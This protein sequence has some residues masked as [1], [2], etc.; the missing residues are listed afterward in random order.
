MAIEHLTML[1]SAAP[2]ATTV[3]ERGIEAF[4][5]RISGPLTPKR[6]AMDMPNL[7]ATAAQAID[8]LDMAVPPDVLVVVEPALGEFDMR[9]EP[10]VKSNAVFKNA[11][12]HL[13]ACTGVFSTYLLHFR[14]EILENARWAREVIGYQS[15]FEK[16]DNVRVLSK[17]CQ[18][19]EPAYEWAWKQWSDSGIATRYVEWRHLARMLKAQPGERG[20]ILELAFDL[21]P[22]V[23][24]REQRQPVDLLN[25]GPRFTRLAEML[26]QQG[27]ASGNAD[28]SSFLNNLLIGRLPQAVR[29]ERTTW[30]AGYSPAAREFLQWL[31]TKGRGPD[32][33]TYLG[34]ILVALMDQ[35]SVEDC[36]LIIETTEL[37]KLMGDAEIAAARDKFGLNRQP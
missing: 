34:V 1:G 2:L 15:L 27:T 10:R 23:K 29:S 31:H 35:V 11:K 20:E 13:A 32:G 28:P 37:F 33:N 26:A 36:T 24:R 3:L 12:M 4:T 19:F 18:D 21:P 6:G 22:T 30:G 9:V 14:K 8:L 5:K 16:G 7:P 25:D 17:D